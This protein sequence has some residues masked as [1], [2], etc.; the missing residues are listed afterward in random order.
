MTRTELAA[1]G[2]R[3]AVHSLP[4]RPTAAGLARD[5]AA[6]RR[7][8]RLHLVAG[9]SLFPLLTVLLIGGTVLWGPWVTLVL[10]LATWNVVGRLG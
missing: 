1:S 9:R 10:A 6:P 8:L 4:P 2:H 3:S 5:L 7:S